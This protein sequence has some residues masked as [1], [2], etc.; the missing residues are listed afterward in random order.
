MDEEALAAAEAAK[1]AAE[2]KKLDNSGSDDS[3]LSNFWDELDDDK[4]ATQ[5]SQQQQSTESPNAV[6]DGVLKELSFPQVMD[7]NIMHDLS[8]GKVEGFNEK[9]LSAQQAGVKQSLLLTGKLLA[10]FKETL[11]TD[12]NKTINGRL[13]EQE[14]LTFLDSQLPKN[15]PTVKPV[16]KALFDQALVRTKGNKEQAIAMTK[17]ML[18][19]IGIVSGEGNRDRERSHRQG[20]T[21]KVDWAAE[22]GLTPEN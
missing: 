12:I 22:L 16:I 10:N 11:M 20:S 8:E 18:G 19:R 17:Q 3:D 15:D 4:E 2:V 13:T 1:K 9:L 5:Q 21:D 6:L 14:N 7:E